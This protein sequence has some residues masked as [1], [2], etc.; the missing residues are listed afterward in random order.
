MFLIDKAKMKE[1]IGFCLKGENTGYY[2]LFWWERDA[3][4]FTEIFLECLAEDETFNQ[5]LTEKNVNASCLK[6]VAKFK[7]QPIPLSEDNE[8]RCESLRDVDDTSE[9]CELLQTNLTNDMA[10]IINLLKEGLHVEHAPSCFIYGWMTTLYLH[11]S[12]N[13]Y[14]DTDKLLGLGYLYKAYTQNFAPAVVLQTWSGRY[15]NITSAMLPSL[16]IAI[17][18]GY[19]PAMYCVANDCDQELYHDLSQWNQETMDALGISSNVVERLSNSPNEMTDFQKSQYMDEQIRRLVSFNLRKQAAQRGDDRAMGHLACDYRTG[20]GTKKDRVEATYWAQKHY[21]ISG[22]YFF[23]S[24]EEINFFK[25]EACFFTEKSF[26]QLLSKHELSHI[27]FPGSENKKEHIEIIKKYPFITHVTFEY[28]VSPPQVTEINSILIDNRI[29]KEGDPLHQQWKSGMSIIETLKEVDD[30]NRWLSNI[31][32]RIKENRHHHRIEENEVL[33][34]IFSYFILKI[35]SDLT[36]QTFTEIKPYLSEKNNADIYFALAMQRTEC[37]GTVASLAYAYVSYLYAMQPH[38]FRQPSIP[39]NW[40]LN[41]LHQEIFPNQSELLLD[42]GTILRSQKGLILLL[43]IGQALDNLSLELDFINHKSLLKEGDLL[44]CLHPQNRYLL[45]TPLLK[46]T[47]AQQEKI[48]TLKNKSANT[49]KWN[50]FREVRQQSI[51]ITGDKRKEI[52]EEEK[53][54]QQPHKKHKSSP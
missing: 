37:N 23:L 34:S 53:T 25:P 45:T 46:M 15:N 51:A 16:I 11:P 10:D 5:L 24:N 32:A 48:Q 21:F 33:V 2:D 13:E 35:D 27:H 9:I 22:E 28:P 7:Q 36:L 8:L 38:S 44:A 49:N 26:D 50:D 40:L 3:R 43:N 14:Y 41:R 4:N 20:Y 18:E 30:I 52:D 6:A 54:D 31:A 42:E 39:K 17:K 47:A 12:S 1:A 29:A 19:V